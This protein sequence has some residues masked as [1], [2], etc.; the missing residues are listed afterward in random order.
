MSN[1]HV[2]T[3]VILLI[4]MLLII[5]YLIDNT[6]ANTIDNNT[7]NDIV[8][9][10]VDNNIVN[11]INYF[12]PFQL[13]IQVRGMTGVD[14]HPI[15]PTHPF[16]GLNKVLSFLE[17]EAFL[18]STFFNSNPMLNTN[19]FRQILSALRNIYGVSIALLVHL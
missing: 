8:D 2:N 9:N 3:F 15:P 11:T 19:L 5:F 13:S 6:I 16:K 12:L 7:D 1:F 10:N 4:I 18:I 17:V 14:S